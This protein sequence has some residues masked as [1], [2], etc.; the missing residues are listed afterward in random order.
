MAEYNTRNC[1]ICGKEIVITTGWSY[2]RTVDHRARY[3]CSWACLRIDETKNPEVKKDLMAEAVEKPRPKKQP[4]D[5]GKTAQAIVEEIKAGRNPIKFLKEAGYGNP[6]EAYNA[7]RHFA[8]T[9]GMQEVLKVMLPLRQLKYE[10]KK[11]TGRP[12]KT[13]VTIV[14][15][16]PAIESS[17]KWDGSTPAAGKKRK[18]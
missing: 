5:R 11:P 8:E 1:A 13:Q 18:M 6:Y 12:R 2:K 9:K 17:G 14:D 16:V 7:V 15:S 4:Q 10:R 3:F